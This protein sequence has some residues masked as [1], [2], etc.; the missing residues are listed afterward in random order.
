MSGQAVKGVYLA[1]Q[2]QLDAHKTLGHGQPEKTRQ[3]SASV[4]SAST[5]TTESAMREKRGDL[6]LARGTSSQ[7]YGTR[8]SASTRAENRSAQ[9]A[10]RTLPSWIASFDEDADNIPNS[11]PT[12]RLIAA[13]NR[14]H[15]AQ[16]HHS[17][18][19][20]EHRMSTDGFVDDYEDA[21]PGPN[22]KKPQTGFFG[23]KE[24]VRGRKWDHARSA[25]PVIL[26]A[27]TMRANNTEVESRWRAFARSSIYDTAH[28]ED[29]QLMDQAFLDAQAPGLNRPWR[30]DMGSA[31]DEEKQS[32]FLH[33]K[34]R[35]RTLIK[36]L[37]HVLLMHPL[38]PLIFRLI[39]TATSVIALSISAS[40]FQLSSKYSYKQNPSTIM[41]IV[42]DVVAIPYILY[43]TWDEYTGKPLGL[44]SPKAKIRLVLLDLFFIIFE[45]A[46]LA[47]SFAALTDNDGSCGTGSIGYSFDIC[48]RTKALSGILM[49][50]LISWGLTFAVSIFRLVERVGG[51]E[52][53]D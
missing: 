26:R 44:R 16:H 35:Q 32:N 24:P 13:P 4:S 51:R 52:E 43:I 53:D 6:N 41:A 27:P 1:N 46:N 50:A 20:N 47:I 37:Q 9:R 28:D 42:V 3:A 33:N 34:K 15:A 17:T 8:S 29:S 21:L 5:E 49:L 7:S 36:R 19:S 30:G 25:D 11:R 22:A 18:T 38:V 45:S 14:A 48:S 31:N 39:I 10:V 2:L 40:I 12:D 23:N